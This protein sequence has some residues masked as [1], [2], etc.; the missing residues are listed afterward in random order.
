MNLSKP[1]SA[2]P[3]RAAPGFLCVDVG[4]RGK[5][6]L[7]HVNFA[8]ARGSHQRSFAVRRSEI[9]IGAGL[10][11][12]PDQFEIAVRRGVHDGRGAIGVFALVSCR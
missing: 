7:C 2:A 8:A 6:H 11:Q 3:C 12:C 9:G 5:K 1:C 10:K 4:S